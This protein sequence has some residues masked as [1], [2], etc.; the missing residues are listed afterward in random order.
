MA[1]KFDRVIASLHRRL[2]KETS[3]DLAIGMHYPAR[4]DPFFSGYMTLAGIYRYPTK[5]YD[6]HLRQLTLGADH[7][8]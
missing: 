7:Q 2:D 5:H 4:W 6:F 1:A 8:L 3:A